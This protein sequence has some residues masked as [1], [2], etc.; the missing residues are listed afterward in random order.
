MLTAA[1]VLFTARNAVMA[2]LAGLALAASPA[3]A[4]YTLTSNASTLAQAIA[5]NPGQVTGAT[6]TAIPPNGTPHALSSD[7][8]TGFPTDGA[9]FAVLTTGDASL[10]YRQFLGQ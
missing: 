4:A 5:Q 6:F 9:D 3:D 7:P 10:A 2:V 1:R 8:L